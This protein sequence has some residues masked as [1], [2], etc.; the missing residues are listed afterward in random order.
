MKCQDEVYL[1][2]FFK[3][4]V[5]F[6][7]GHPKFCETQKVTH[8]ELKN[9]ICFINLLSVFIESNKRNTFL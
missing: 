5:C 1:A 4:R 6:K 9:G 3:S 8:R 2:C 7:A